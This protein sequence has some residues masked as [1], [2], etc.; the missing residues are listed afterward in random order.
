[1]GIRIKWS[2]PA[3]NQGS[4]NLTGVNI[5]RSVSGSDYQLYTFVPAPDSSY[6]DS[7]FGLILGNLYCYKLQSVYNGIHD[8]CESALSDERCLVWAYGTD[9]QEMS[10]EINVYPNPAADQVIVSSGKDLKRITAYDAMG[11]L[12]INEEVIGK[13]I[14]LN[15]AAFANGMY[16]LRIENSGGTATRI[17]T[18]KK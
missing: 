13:E 2:T 12:L 9:D 6:L 11:R 8:S 14:E 3:S 17:L 15:T 1:M 4:R 7:G 5:W 10:P 16:L 18:I